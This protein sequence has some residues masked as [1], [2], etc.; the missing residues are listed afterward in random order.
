MDR[1]PFREP[2][3]PGLLLWWSCASFSSNLHIHQDPSLFKLLRLYKLR[4]AAF[5][6]NSDLFKLLQ[7]CKSWTSASFQCSERNFF[8]C[9]FP[10]SSSH[11]IVLVHLVSCVCWGFRQQA[12]GAWFPCKDL[13]LSITVLMPQSSEPHHW[14]AAVASREGSWPMKLPNSRP[15][16][17][18][19]THLLAPAPPVYVPPFVGNSGP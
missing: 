9:W 3:P 8:C 18:D 15:L 17:G 5:H 7:L 2:Q 6:Q 19:A 14:F 16:P 12:G 11:F 10:L 1:R 13:K 4:H